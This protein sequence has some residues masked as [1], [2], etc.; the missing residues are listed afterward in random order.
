MFVIKTGNAKFRRSMGFTVAAKAASL[1]VIGSTKDGFRL[2]ALT[3]EQPD[4]L[5][6]VGPLNGFEKQSDAVA[7]GNDRFGVKA[8]KVAAKD[9]EAAVAA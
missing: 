4:R 7:Y 8:A 6:L 5:Y 1:K 3:A 2:A 9:I